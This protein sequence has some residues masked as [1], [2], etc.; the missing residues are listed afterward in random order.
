MSQSLFGNGAENITHDK[1]WGIYL[2]GPEDDYCTDAMC[3]NPFRWQW[4]KQEHILNVLNLNQMIR[5]FLQQ[6][7]ATDLN[8]SQ[9]RALKMLMGLLTRILEVEPNYTVKLRYLYVCVQ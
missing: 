2:N 9:I 1:D 6:F 3:F 5:L 4:N 7:E 8:S